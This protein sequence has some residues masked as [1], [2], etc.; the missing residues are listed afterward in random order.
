MP[1]ASRPTGQPSRVYI[2][3]Q[4]D[5]LYDIARNELGRASRWGEIYDLNWDQLGNR[6]DG[7]VPGMKLLLPEDAGQP[8]EVLSRNPNPPTPAPTL[9]R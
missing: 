1:A 6:V 7:L 5:T 8:A 4:G 3:K 2:V 9:Q